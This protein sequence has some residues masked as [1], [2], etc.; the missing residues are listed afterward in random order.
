MCTLSG[1]CDRAVTLTQALHQLFFI[2]FQPR[3]MSINFSVPP[4]KR[5]LNS[6]SAFVCVCNFEVRERNFAQHRIR[7]SDIS[8]HG[9][10]GRVID[11]CDTEPLP[12]SLWRDSRYSQTEVSTLQQCT[13]ISWVESTTT[14]T[15]LVYGT[16]MDWVTRQVNPSEGSSTLHGLIWSGFRFQ[17]NLKTKTVDAETEGTKPIPQPTNGHSSISWSIPPPPPP[18][19]S[20][21]RSAQLSTETTS[22]Y[23]WT[24]PSDRFIH[25]PPS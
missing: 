2:P 9:Q 24:Q 17:S 11:N 14:H 3:A 15:Q 10:T 20:S 5:I 12:M 25:L 18:S 19:T 4:S 21:W 22:P 23:H 1:K 16:S 8:K 13:A 7:V 6:G